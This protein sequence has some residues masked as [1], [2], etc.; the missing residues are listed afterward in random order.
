MGVMVNKR[1]HSGSSMPREQLTL[2]KPLRRLTKAYPKGKMVNF[3]NIAFDSVTAMYNQTNNN[4]TNTQLTQRRG[5]HV[6]R[7]TLAIDQTR[8][9]FLLEQ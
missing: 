4:N 1:S 5:R 6:Q 3:S 9:D 8:G 2:S 7:E